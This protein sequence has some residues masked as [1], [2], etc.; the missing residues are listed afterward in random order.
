MINIG[1][2]K[3]ALGIAAGIG[4]LLFIGYCI[5]F[6][7]RRHSDPNFKKK[8]REKRKQKRLAKQAGTKIPDLRD[9]ESVQKFFLSEVQLGETLL[10]EGDVDGAVE[11]LGS[12][13]AVCG[14]PQQLLQILQQ[15]LP[16][17]VFHLLLQRLPMIG[18]SFHAR[19]QASF[20]APVGSSGSSQGSE[21]PVIGLSG[22][23]PTF[24][25]VEDDLE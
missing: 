9:Q 17:Q 14:H 3:S 11:H 1:L 18:Q 20:G 16:P 24:L 2:P 19:H 8:L 7:Q 15:T 22:P 23:P 6:D 10:S 12:A 5:Y 21:P 4:G 25:S 13:I